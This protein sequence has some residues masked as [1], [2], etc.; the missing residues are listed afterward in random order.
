MGRSAATAR[1]IKRHGSGCE[2]CGFKLRTG[3]AADASAQPDS[4]ASVRFEPDQR[5]AKA[6]PLEVVGEFAVEGLREGIASG[7]DPMRDLTESIEMS[8]RIA[9]V[10]CAVSDEGKPMSQSVGEFTIG[11]GGSGHG[12]IQGIKCLAEF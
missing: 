6:R 4:C 1:T 7:I 3:L 8:L 11:F 12:E 2:G 5:L 10:E 9:L